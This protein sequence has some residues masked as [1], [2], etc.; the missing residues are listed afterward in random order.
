MPKKEL[1]GDTRIEKIKSPKQR[2]VREE[3]GSQVITFGRKFFPD[4]WSVVSIGN[5]NKDSVTIKRV[6]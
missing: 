2:F 5:I 4:N 3:H 6:A 1:S